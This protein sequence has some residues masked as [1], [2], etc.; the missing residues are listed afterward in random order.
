MMAQTTK[1]RPPSPPNPSAISAD[2]NLDNQLKALAA[3]IDLNETEN[4]DFDGDID[5]DKELD[6]LCNESDDTPNIGEGPKSP[7]PPIPTL[8]ISEEPDIIYIEGPQP[9]QG[10]TSARPKTPYKKQESKKGI[11]EPQILPYD[12]LFDY[13]ANLFYHF[14]ISLSHPEIAQNYFNII[15][16]LAPLIFQGEDQYN[17]NGQ[18]FNVKNLPQPFPKE[19]E[20]QQVDE[21]E[22]VTPTIF[23]ENEKINT[24][25]NRQLSRLTEKKKE[26]LKRN[27]TQSVQELDRAISLTERSLNS[28]YDPPIL[29]TDYIHLYPSN[30]NPD[31]KHNEIKIVF[32]SVLKNTKKSKDRGQES[33]RITIILGQLG[34]FSTPE[35][36]N[37]F[38]NSLDYSLTSD[39]LT[40]IKTMMAVFSG[41]ARIEIGDQATEV[42]LSP[43][44]INCTYPISA[45]VDDT[46]VL[47]DIMIHSPLSA[48]NKQRESMQFQYLATFVDE[49]TTPAPPVSKPPTAVGFA[50]TPTVPTPTV[51][52]SR[53]RNGERNPALS[54]T[55]K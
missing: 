53:S 7:L 26:C 45:T 25:L 38:I 11:Q 30:I 13:F 51:R 36:T 29:L 8:A 48:R 17:P 42:P 22:I 16:K 33:Y 47:I 5:L 1:R 6:K 34:H 46:T 28:V 32:K 20:F 19:F 4:E 54:R 55:F 43:L 52:Q 31:L 14:T 15:Q 10:E 37:S 35:L 9:K 40:D 2:A 23:T 21:N 3:E 12:K 49:I 27:E 50:T 24:I 44:L 18:K 41:N 39:K